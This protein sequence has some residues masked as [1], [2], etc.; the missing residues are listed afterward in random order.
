MTS[1]GGTGENKF[2]SEGAEC[3]N[4]Q[5]KNLSSVWFVHIFPKGAQERNIPPGIVHSEEKR[6]C[7]SQTLLFQSTTS[8]GEHKACHSAK[9]S[10]IC[11]WIA[12]WSGLCTPS[13]SYEMQFL[14]FSHEQ[15]HLYYFFRAFVP[16]EITFTS[17]LSLIIWTKI[18]PSFVLL[19]TFIS[20]LSSSLF[21]SFKKCFP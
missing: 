6:G 12:A 21:T 4:E 15:F 18:P 19:A 2:Q 16:L 1:F 9:S 3:A 11:Q 5:T 10:V 14:T 20:H 8:A 7:N 17:S 13:C